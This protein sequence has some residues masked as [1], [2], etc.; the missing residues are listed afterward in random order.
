MLEV[1]PEGLRGQSI[2]CLFIICYPDLTDAIFFKK[3]G[4]TEKRGFEFEIGD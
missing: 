3:E 2:L 4:A 1:N